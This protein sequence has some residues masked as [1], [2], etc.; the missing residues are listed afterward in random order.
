MG[1]GKSSME[2]WIKQLREERQGETPKATALTP[3][4][5]EIQQLKRELW[6]ISR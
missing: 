3:E 6:W 1:V 2:Y 4:Q 5:R